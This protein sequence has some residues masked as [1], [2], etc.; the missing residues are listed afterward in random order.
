MA[1]SAEAQKPSALVRTGTAKAESTG[2]TSAAVSEVRLHEGNEQSCFECCPGTGK[3]LCVC[4]TCN[5]TGYGMI[6]PN[7]CTIVCMW[8]TLLVPTV[9][10]GLFAVPFVSPD[11]GWYWVLAY[12]MLGGLVGSYF[13]ASC[14]DPGIARGYSQVTAP[15]SAHG[16]SLHMCRSCDRMQT[17]HARHC[18]ECGVC[19]NDLDH[20]CPFMGHCVGGQTLRYFYFFLTA[21]VIV[22]IFM[23]ISLIAGAAS[24]SD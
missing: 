23:I 22:P 15:S 14:T 9:T 13:M 18:G 11:F 2:P 20:H 8:V 10:F 5:G 6:G 3:Y 19:I 24:S 16:K 17:S 1:G 21:V 4:F 12:C 7:Y